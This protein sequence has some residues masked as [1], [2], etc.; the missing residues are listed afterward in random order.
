MRWASSPIYT[1]QLN[2][3]AEEYRV[4]INAAILQC[5]WDRAVALLRP[6]VEKD[7]DNADALF[8]LGYALHANGQIDEAIS[9]HKLAQ[10][11]DSVKPVATYNLACALAIKG[12]HEEALATLK[13]SIACGF[14]PKLNLTEDPDLQSL[15]RLPEFAV[16]NASV[17]MHRITPDLVD[18][19][20]SGAIRT[21]F[22]VPTKTT[23]PR[24]P[25]VQSVSHGSANGPVTATC[26][27]TPSVNKTRRSIDSRHFSSMLHNTIAT[28]SF[29]PSDEDVRIAAK[30]RTP[31]T[32]TVD[33]ELRLQ[34]LANG[35]I[36]QTIECK[37]E[38][39]GLHFTRSRLV[40][41]EALLPAGGAWQTM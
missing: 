9:Y 24:G 39:A 31:G 5:D 11:F 21:L 14:T 32:P 35:C 34:P 12:Q 40:A 36:E 16:L 3:D 18:K 33:A 6:L 22:H 20:D 23:Q 7:P 19:I 41:P 15:F 10:T 17:I 26:T 2:L 27:D 1:A 29:D 30:L 38:S 28:V 13:G 8:F 4:Q 37:I 25:T